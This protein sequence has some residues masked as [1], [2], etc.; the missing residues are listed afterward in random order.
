[1]PPE[2]A[3]P[4]TAPGRSH[5]DMGGVTQFLCAPIDKEHHELTRFDRQVD[6]LRQVLAIHGLFSTDE[7]RR[8]IESLPAEVY[9][10]SSYYQ[11][12]LFS[13]VKVMLEKGVV[14]EDELRSALA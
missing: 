1:M 6:A 14:T 7:M 3:L 4:E 11:R 2:T 9:D 12:W 8:G 5:H 10:A 13:M